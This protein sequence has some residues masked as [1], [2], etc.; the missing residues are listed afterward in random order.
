[1]T[2]FEGILEGRNS[3]DAVNHV[4]LILQGFF[5]VLPLFCVIV[6]TLSMAAHQCRLLCLMGTG[7]C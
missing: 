6:E 7:K 5:V 4:R 2:L 1:M 3:F